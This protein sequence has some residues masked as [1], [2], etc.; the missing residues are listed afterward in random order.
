MRRSP[1]KRGKP[2]KRTPLRYKPKNSGSNFSQQTKQMSAARFHHRCAMSHGCSGRI[3]TFHH[4]RLR[5]SGGQGTV[6]NAL[7]LCTPAHQ[8]IHANPDWSIRHGLIV[9]GGREP[10]SVDL[11]LDCGLEC[12]EDHARQ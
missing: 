1:I 11:F 3:E 6:D 9:R 5:S 12:T 8:Q 10:A 7:P 4:R 2:L